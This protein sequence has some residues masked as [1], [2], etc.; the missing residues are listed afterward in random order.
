MKGK[1][2]L[3][4]SR[5]QLIPKKNKKKTKKNTY[6]LR[7]NLRRDFK[8]MSWQMHICGIFC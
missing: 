5:H 6:K 7:N 2:S 4:K 3:D 8:N 1:C